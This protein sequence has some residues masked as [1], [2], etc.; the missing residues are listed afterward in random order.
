M[1]RPSAAQLQALEPLSV[2][3]VIGQDALAA[4]DT[5]TAA[6]INVV[7]GP[8]VP[9][10]AGALGGALG[11]AI[12]D[13]QIKAEAKRFAERHVQPLRLALRGFDAKSVLS[14]S[15]QQA[16]SR[17][18]A[19]FSGYTRTP[20]TPVSTSPHLVVQTTYSMTP[21]F[22]ALQVIASVSIRGAGGAQGKPIYNNVLVYQSARR[23]APAKTAE[24]RER[25]VAQENR[26]YAQLHVDQDIDKANAELER[27]DP[28]VAHLREKI[29]HEQM[30]HRQ[31]LAQ[32]SA[33]NWDAD[34]RAQFL[35]EAWAVNHGEALKVAMRDSGIEIANMLMLDLS[36]Q[37]GV[38][39][40]EK[41]HT[42]SANGTRKIAYVAGGHMIS[43]ALQDDDASLKR[44]SP[45]V[46]V[47][48]NSVGHG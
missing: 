32:A 26:R 44:L 47:P 3:E 13:A 42:V 21:D 17:Q 10:V 48:L 19:D 38:G 11:M 20:A 39:Q 30:E 28:E 45:M 25:L 4:Q 7:P 24:D 15:L 40:V 31:R 14:D 8:G 2:V 35:A 23:V 27:R 22:S 41:P 5:Y 43:M 18:P 9:I 46:T 1:V 12:V 36:D 33:V 6:N 16:L 34:S 29:D 37:A